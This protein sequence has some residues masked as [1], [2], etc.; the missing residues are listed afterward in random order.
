MSA[1]STRPASSLSCLCSPRME[2]T[3]NN[4]LI[5]VCPPP[6][7][8]QVSQME[9]QSIQTQHSMTIKAQSDKHQPLLLLL[10]EMPAEVG[11][12]TILTTRQIL[13]AGIQ[14]QPTCT[15]FQTQEVT[16]VFLRMYLR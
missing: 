10:L 7:H 9:V 1:F 8:R 13:E 12:K 2:A 16:K 5:S 11:L 4:C 3:H 15:T 6:I 14:G